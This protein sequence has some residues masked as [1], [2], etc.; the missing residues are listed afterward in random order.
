MEIIRTNEQGE[1]DVV[2]VSSQ[3]VRE[4]IIFVL[5]DYGLIYSDTRPQDLRE[6]LA[7]LRKIRRAAQRR[8]DVLQQVMVRSMVLGALAMLILGTA[9]YLKG[10]MNGID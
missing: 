6:D 9:H 7:Y 4:E 1:L 3:V 8:G 5:A 2:C 10:V